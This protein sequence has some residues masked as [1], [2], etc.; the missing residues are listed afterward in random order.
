[1]KM[2]PDQRVLAPSADLFIHSA[3]KYLMLS[4]VATVSSLS[5]HMVMRTL[6]ARAAADMPTQPCL[7]AACSLQKRK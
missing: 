4:A 6:A 5:I 7:S 3:P 2:G 1:M